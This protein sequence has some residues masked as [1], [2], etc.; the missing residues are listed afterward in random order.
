MWGNGGKLLDLGFTEISYCGKSLCNLDFV[1]ADLT[2]GQ[3]VG[4]LLTRG[5]DLHWFVD[6]Q[7]KGEVHVGDY[8]LDE[9]M[10]GVVDVYGNCNQV[11]AEI[12]T[13]E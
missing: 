3:S 5:R 7:W 4:M 1:T 10:W 6:D 8:P 13:G 12:C 11:R 2:V 9:L